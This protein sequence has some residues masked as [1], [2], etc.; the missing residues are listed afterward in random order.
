[1]TGDDVEMRNCP[2]EGC[3]YGPQP[4]SSVAAHYSGTTEQPDHQG[5]Y[6]RAKSRL[7][8]S[9]TQPDDPDPEPPDGDTDGDAEA[10]QAG[11]QAG[12]ADTTASGDGLGLS[13]P[14]DVGGSDDSPE[15][16]SGTQQSPETGDIS[17]PDGSLGILAGVVG[18]GA[19]V[20]VLARSRGAQN[21]S[22][23]EPEYE[24]V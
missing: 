22:Q 13:G 19:L 6:E 4:I 9:D 7:A 24:L 20:V 15:P 17:T 2:A 10:T 11:A 1:M 21:D 14:P 5:G 12:G 18:L 16:S 3:D 8:Q 23:D